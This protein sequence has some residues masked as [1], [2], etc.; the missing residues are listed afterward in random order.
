M[1]AHVWMI[2]LGTWFVLV[3][4]NSASDDKTPQAEPATSHSHNGPDSSAVAIAVI[5][6]DPQGWDDVRSFMQDLPR[7]STITIYYG[8]GNVLSG[9]HSRA[10][11]LLDSLVATES[12]KP[13]DQPAT[14]P[15]FSTALTSAIG[16]SLR[17]LC[18]HTRTVVLG[19][20]PPLLLKTRA[21]FERVGPIITKTE[22]DALSALP[23]H[24][25]IMLGP[26]EP[27]V[28]RDMLLRAFQEANS[29]VISISYR[30]GVNQ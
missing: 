17:S 4:C 21:D 19:T 7:P 14:L 26:S 8:D 10:I 28:L 11:H 2:V 24:K 16:S 20:F 1:Q 30:T 18:K 13:S 15:Y 6:L 12:L 29:N 27:S 9:N 5:S 22:L 3:S 23:D 25:F